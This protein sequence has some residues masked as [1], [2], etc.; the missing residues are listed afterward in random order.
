MV[1]E[2]VGHRKWRPTFIFRERKLAD[3]ALLV[4][5]SRSELSRCDG[6]Q[7]KSHC[8]PQA[9][10]SGLVPIMD[11]PKELGHRSCCK[12]MDHDQSKGQT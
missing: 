7:V 4:R 12:T 9:L 2:S 10:M 1:A 8:L 5:V 3:Q 11:D 6:F